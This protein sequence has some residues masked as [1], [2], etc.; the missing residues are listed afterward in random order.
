MKE[1]NDGAEPSSSSVAASNLIRLHR[2]SSLLDP[3]FLQK[4]DF[5]LPDSYL[6]SN[7]TIQFDTNIW[8]KI[9]TYCT[10]QITFN[11][12]NNLNIH[13]VVIQCTSILYIVLRAHWSHRALEPRASWEDPHFDDGTKSFSRRTSCARVVS[14]TGED[15]SFCRLF[16][17]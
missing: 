15:L 12:S 8:Y 5:E 11:T 16:R 14:A 13:I 17:N 4:N 1:D 2:I 9:S 6:S 3:E 10:I 7:F